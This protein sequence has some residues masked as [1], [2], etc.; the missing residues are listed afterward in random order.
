VLTAI[1]FRR[2]AILTVI[3]IA[4]A[5][6]A[7]AAATRVIPLDSVREAVKSEIRAAT[8]LN[9]MLRG[10]VSISMFPAATVN[11]SDV[12]LGEQA[13][14]EQAFTVEQLTANLRLMPTATPTGHPCSTL[15]RTL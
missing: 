1:S 8:G 10:P 7:V 13:G 2:F 6:A 12:V 9:P 15:W 5:V 14:A 4:T 11:F 3:V